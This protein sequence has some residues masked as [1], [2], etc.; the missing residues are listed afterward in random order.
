MTQTKFKRVPFD[1]ELAKKIT[2]KEVKGRI[3]TEDKLTAR[4]I[5]FDMR[6]GGSKNL[7]ALVDCGDMKSG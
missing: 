1:I 5:C 7:A 3:V 6:Y 4:I 2:N